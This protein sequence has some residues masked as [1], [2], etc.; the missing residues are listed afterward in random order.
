MWSSPLLLLT[1]AASPSVEAGGYVGNATCA[2]CHADIAR[3][4]GDHPMARSSGRL[5]GPGSPALPAGEFTHA[6][7]G[8]RYRMR[9][10]GDG[11]LVMEYRREGGPRPLAGRLDCTLFMG[12]HKGFSFLY[13]KDGSLYQAP[14]AF[15]PGQGRWDMAPGYEDREYMQLAR[16]VPLGCVECHAS[17]AQPVAGT[18]NRFETPPFLENGVGCERCH[19]P[20]AAHRDW[21]LGG[22]K[23]QGPG[24][25]NPAKL[26][27]ERRDSVCAQC[28]LRGETRVQRQGCGLGTFRPGQA[29]AEVVQAYVWAGDSGPLDATSHYQKLRESTCKRR[30]GDRFWCV[31]CH[32]PH[33]AVPSAERIAH[34]RSR[35]LACHSAEACRASPEKRAERGGDC[36]A[37]HMPTRTNETIAHAVATD[38]TIPRVADRARPQAPSPGSRDLVPFWGGASPLRELGQA[39]ASLPTDS[40]LYKEK[41]DDLLRRAYGEGARDATTLILLA[42]SLESSGSPAKALPLYEEAVARGEGCPEELSVAE[43]RLGFLLGSRGRLAEARRLFEQALFRTPGY[44]AAWVNRAL[45]A[46]MA[47]DRKAAED[48][49]AGALALE[50]DSPALNQLLTEFRA[51]AAR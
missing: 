41:A 34:F 7:S 3:T 36:T 35:C 42:A 44:E 12:V 47:G 13:L 26:P 11:T 33:R 5:G 46:D 48:A 43:N 15:Y 14:V 4:F 24:I 27:P 16:P 28:H 25:V 37:C 45:V 9:T 51:S 17:R 38:H 23:G 29:L 22:K 8:V 32:D 40:H 1:L 2:A 49:F 30:A 50:P 6:L 10:E 31:S 21:V 20:G 19:G 39:Y 18:Q